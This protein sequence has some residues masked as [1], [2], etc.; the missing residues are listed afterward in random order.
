VPSNEL[1]L[2]SMILYFHKWGCLLLLPLDSG[3]VLERYY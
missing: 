1:T 2:K 3:T